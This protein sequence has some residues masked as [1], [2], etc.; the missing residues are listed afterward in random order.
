MND[1]SYNQLPNLGITVE[2]NVLRSVEVAYED[3]STKVLAVNEVEAS[4]DLWAAISSGTDAKDKILSYLEPIIEGLPGR[5][6]SISFALNR[7]WS[8]ISVHHVDSGLPDD[9]KDEF[10]K[11]EAEKKLGYS[12]NDYLIDTYLLTEELPKYSKYL[13]VAINNNLIQM[14]QSLSSSVDIPVEFVDVDI[15][16][17]INSVLFTY[18][19]ARTG[20]VA[21]LRHLDDNY[22]VTILKDGEFT[23]NAFFHVDN[24]GSTYL[25]DR[26]EKDQ[27][28]EELITS[29]SADNNSDPLK[30][31]EKLFIYNGTQKGE[32]LT[33]FTALY[34]KVSI[35]EVDP[36]KGLELH[37]SISAPL[38]SKNSGRFTETLGMAIRPIIEDEVL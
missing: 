38:L 7:L 15:F 22:S 21:I 26:T 8:L 25:L 4:D 2:G 6:N 13:S 9:E 12:S 34:D 31:V 24:D 28:F 19:Q 23:G 1:E 27:G 14:F 37:E 20:K 18:A 36:F 35:I 10:V 5:P 11:W 30:V 33:H 16:A 32:L 3:K 17:G 29:L